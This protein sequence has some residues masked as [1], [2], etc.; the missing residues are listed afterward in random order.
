VGD[1][2]TV[3]VVET[4]EA[5][6][7]ASTGVSRNS[8]VSAEVTNFLG[9]A[10]TTSGTGKFFEPKVAASTGNSFQ[11]AGSTKHKDVLRTRVAARVAHILEDGNLVIE[12]RRQVRIQQD[13]QYLYV[14]GVA[15]TVDISSKNTIESTAL[16]DAQI[17]YGGG[18]LVANQQ[19]PGWMYQ[20]L[21]KV[22]PF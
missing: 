1:L 5:Q 14:R 8:S 3:I 20:I 16:A 21:D 7:E 13:T 9:S 6:R 4:S 18:G 19:Q 12:G 22:W 17:L 10:L 2:V 11:G 15:R